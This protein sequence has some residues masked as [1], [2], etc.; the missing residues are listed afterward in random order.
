MITA[1]AK[2]S[3]HLGSLTEEVEHIIDRYGVAIS[4]ELR[5]VYVDMFMKF[6]IIFVVVVF[7]NTRYLN[8]VLRFFCLSEMS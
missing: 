1:I 7:F 2:L 6:V 8:D 3:A 4:G 5:Q